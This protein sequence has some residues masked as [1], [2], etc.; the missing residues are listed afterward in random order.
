[1]TS[2]SDSGK[3]NTAFEGYASSCAPYAR[4]AFPGDYSSKSTSH[5][6]IL[7]EPAA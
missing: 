6:P 2:P 3:W 4:T 5:Y 1:M 7:A